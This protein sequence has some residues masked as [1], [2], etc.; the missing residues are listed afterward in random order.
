ALTLPARRADAARRRLRRIDRAVAGHLLSAPHAEGNS[1]PPRCRDRESAGRARG[2]RPL[3]RDRPRAHRRLAPAFL[4]RRGERLREVR[5]AGA[6]AAD[7]PE[8]SALK[9]SFREDPAFC[10]SSQR[11]AMFGFAIE[12]RFVTKATGLRSCGSSTGRILITPSF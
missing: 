3:C 12:L 5:Q 2:A 4:D 9:S 10:V 6:R 1:L 7:Q 11:M 8:L